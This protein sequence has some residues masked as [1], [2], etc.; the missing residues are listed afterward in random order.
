MQPLCLVDAVKARL[1]ALPHDA[2]QVGAVGETQL[3]RLGMNPLRPFGLV[4]SHEP[5]LQAEKR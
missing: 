2:L 5:A 4:V 3:H 1:L